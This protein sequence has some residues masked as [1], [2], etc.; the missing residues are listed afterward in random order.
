LLHSCG[1]SRSRDD[2]IIAGQVAEHD[3]DLL[4][5]SD[6]SEDDNDL[7]PWLPARQDSCLS[8]ERVGA[9]GFVLRRSFDSQN[10]PVQCPL[11]PSFCRMSS[12]RLSHLSTMTAEAEMIKSEQDRWQSMM[13]I[14]SQPVTFQRMTT[15]WFLGCQPDKTAVCL[16]NECDLS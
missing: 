3:D 8:F 5:A 16:S 1:D 10:L 12:V 4:S 14:C 6:V 7:V 2:Q 15:A 9:V 13:T 11:S